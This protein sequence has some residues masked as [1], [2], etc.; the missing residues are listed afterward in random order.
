MVAT[1]MR[2]GRQRSVNVNNLHYAL[3]YVNDA[4][5]RETAKQLHLTLVTKNIAV[6]ALKPKQTAPPSPNLH[7]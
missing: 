2:P 7:L 4:T 5:L 1:V 3:D 6:D